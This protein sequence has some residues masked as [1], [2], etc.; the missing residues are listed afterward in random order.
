MNII[1]EVCQSLFNEIYFLMDENEKGNHNKTYF[2]LR[3]SYKRIFV[4][5]LLFTFLFS[6]YVT[7][8]YKKFS[9]GLIDQNFFPIDKTN[10]S[11][12]NVLDLLKTTY[13]K[14]DIDTIT[15]VEEE[16]KIKYYSHNLFMIIWLR[17][18]FPYIFY[19]S[20]KEYIE[21][22]KSILYCYN[23]LEIKKS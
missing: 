13:D 9:F 17:K 6:R 21:S 3:N 1:F 14:I 12:K 11:L 4:N 19:S 8:D 2:K 15:K 16:E 5:Y 10:F 7:I 20:K 23:N 22:T 18:L